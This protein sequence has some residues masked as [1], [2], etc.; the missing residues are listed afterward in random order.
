M[1]ATVTVNVNAVQG[2]FSGA[3]RAA[4][5]FQPVWREFAQYMRVRTDDTFMHLSMGGT[6]RGVRWDYF[7][8]QYTR[9]TDGVTVPAWGGVPKLRGAGAVLGQ[10]RPSG[11]RVKQGDSIL[12]DT[13]T[14]RSRAALV[15]LNSATELRMGPGLNYAAKL[16]EKR[17]FLFF[18]IPQDSRALINLARA[19]LRRMARKGG[20][21]GRI[22]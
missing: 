5:N 1:V 2:M 12:Q 16:Q 14:L 9:R 13:G 8:P 19:H 3:A 18:Q 10:L 15:I 11:Q 21:K 22:R 7:T 20:S 17:P 6:Y 4:A